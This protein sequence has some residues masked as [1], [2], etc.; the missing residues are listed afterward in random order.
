[1]RAYWRIGQAGNLVHYGE[2][3]VMGQVG[4]PLDAPDRDECKMTIQS[5]DG[6]CYIMDSCCR[7]LTKKE[8]QMVNQQIS[9]ILLNAEQS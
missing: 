3:I 7:N 9:R 2:V 5:D 4:K 8:R 6:I 1:M